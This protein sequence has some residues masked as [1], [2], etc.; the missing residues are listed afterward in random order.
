MDQEFVKGKATGLS[1]VKQY[2]QIHTVQDRPV[3]TR[4]RCVHA[5]LHLS[6]TQTNWTSKA[7]VREVT[8]ELE[9]QE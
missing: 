4:S 7:I 3:L 8:L 6:S 9:G 5:N 2:R 1:S